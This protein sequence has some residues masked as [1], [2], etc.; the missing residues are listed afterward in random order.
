MEGEDERVD[1][2]VMERILEL[3]EEGLSPEE[4]IMRGFTFEKVTEAI[5]NGA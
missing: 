2:P 5:K 3:I 4:I 1:L